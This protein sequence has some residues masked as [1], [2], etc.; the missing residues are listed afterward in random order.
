M[1]EPA[2][3]KVDPKLASLL[4][5]GYRSTEHA[6]KE[7]IDNAWDADAEHVWVE[8]PEPDVNPY[9]PIVVRDDGTGMT[10]KEVQSGYLTIAS[11][12][13]TRK[14]ERTPEKK[15]IVKGRKGIGKFAG[16]MAA[17]VM[18]VETWARGKGTRLRISR[19]EL[20]AAGQDLERVPLPFSEE[21]ADGVASGTVV[22][23]TG[24][25][26]NLTFPNPER[27]KRLL[28][29]DYGRESD[30]E[31]IVNGA[32]VTIDAVPGTAFE[33]RVDLPGV[34]MVT[35]RF[36]VAEGKQ[37]ME[38]SGIVVRVGGKVIG[39]PTYFGLDEDEEVPKKLCRRIYG[40][41]EADG[42]ADDVTA[43]WGAIIENSKG[44]RVLEGWAR[45]QLKGGVEARF[46]REVNLQKARLK[47]ELDR[48]LS[49]LP[50][51]RRDYAEKALD[52]VLAK[53]YGESEEKVRVIASVVLEAFEKDEYWAVLRE[54]DRARRRD[55]EDFAEAL[56]AFGLVDIATMA[57]Q[58]HARM[59]MLDEL[60]AL[61]CDD[62]ALEK[63]VHQALERNLWVFGPEYALMSSNKSTRRVVR[64]YLDSE[65]TGARANNR[66]DLFL[67]RDAR[68][69]F[70][71]VELKRPSYAVG[72]R[73][74]AQAMEYRDD[75][76]RHF[77][78]ISEVLVVGGRLDPSV[79][80]R[81]AQDDVR[82]LTYSGLIEEARAQLG[83]LLTELEEVE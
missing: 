73:D 45:T 78:Q 74:Q 46:H 53:F 79:D 40:E 6:I 71:L 25:N 76:G 83:W 50:E 57:R 13:R 31:I 8:L 59:K 61:V 4:G 14:G 55:V 81:H 30:F 26:Q 11:D 20:L 38:D 21:P 58:A 62:G 60:E 82:L 67:A 70:L 22:T 32:P 28:V 1:S 39:D 19:D 2:Y 10:P 9:D 52:R 72:R 63:D 65:Y 47:Q 7:L 3:F 18:E 44:F 36:K 49:R 27:L 66:P 34:G 29:F 77:Q 23:L 24:L 64:D 51:H 37:K 17:A 16:L 56:D 69:C 42:L 48:R 80:L 12:R 75:L 68:G 43:D 35:L 15:R 41:I 54:V 33:E 5:E